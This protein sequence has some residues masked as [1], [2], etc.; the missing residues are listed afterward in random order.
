MDNKQMTWI[1]YFT[2]L[3]LLHSN[4]L[5]RGSSSFDPIPNSH[6]SSSIS[7]D[8]VLDEGERLKSKNQKQHQHQHQQTKQDK[9]QPEKYVKLSEISKDDDLAESQTVSNTDKH[10]LEDELEDEDGDKDNSFLMVDSPPKS[11]ISTLPPISQSPSSSSLLSSPSLGSFFSSSMEKTK[12]NQKQIKERSKIKNKPKK[13]EQKES[14]IETENSIESTK[15]S[16][17]PSPKP[18]K[19][20]TSSW[21]FSFGRTMSTN[22]ES[23]PIGS[24][25]RRFNMKSFSSKESFSSFQSFSPRE[26][27]LQISINPPLPPPF[28]SPPTF[29]KR[30]ETTS[31][32]E[33][34]NAN[35]NASTSVTLNETMKGLDETSMSINESRTPVISPKSSLYSPS[36]SPRVSTP[37]SRFFK[38]LNRHYSEGSIPPPPST[39][40]I[41]IPNSVLEGIA[42]REIYNVNSPLPPLEKKDSDGNDSH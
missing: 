23:S 36:T 12:E 29:L 5:I 4:N 38:S 3:F 33:F 24:P 31:K 28:P 2:L 22:R 11:P 39:S 13:K 9:F 34:S 18:L 8:F 19:S 17:S 37:R 30:L 27:S 7:S 14:E 42:G 32:N 25:K 6:S 35:S 40:H 26:S 1:L 41:I 16:S 21:P 15:S 10:E 20:P